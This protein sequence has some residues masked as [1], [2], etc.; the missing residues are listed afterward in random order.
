MPIPSL[1]E[2]SS[3]AIDVTRATTRASSLWL[4]VSTLDM[5]LSTLLT[6]SCSPSNSSHKYIISNASFITHN[7]VIPE[8][9]SAAKGDTATSTSSEKQAENTPKRSNTIY[10]TQLMCKGRG[11]P[12][13]VPQP[14]LRLPVAQRAQGVSI[15]DVGIITEYGAF[16]FL[17]N[18]CAAADD[19][20]NPPDL[21]EGFTTLHLSAWDV[22]EFRDFPNGS[23]LASPSIG[24]AAKGED[25]RTTTFESAEKEGALLAMPQ[26]AYHEEVN[27]LSKFRDHAEQHVESWYRF[28]MHK[29][30]RRD[31]A[32]G[33]IRLVV[34]VDKSTTWGMA[35]FADPFQLQL[36]ETDG[37]KEVDDLP[38]T[39][40]HTGTSGEVKAGPDKWENEDI[41]PKNGARVRNQTLFARTLNIL[42]G[43][44]AWAKVDTQRNKR[45]PSLILTVANP[46]YEEPQTPISIKASTATMGEKPSNY[47]NVTVENVPRPTE[48]VKGLLSMR[49]S[50][51]RSIQR[52][53]RPLSKTPTLL[54]LS[55]PSLILSAGGSN[56]AKLP[57]ETKPA[58]LQ[59]LRRSHY[60]D[61]GV[62]QRSTQPIPS[63]MPEAVEKRMDLSDT[64]SLS[65]AISQFDSIPRPLDRVR[66][67]PRGG[68]A[69]TAPIRL[70][71]LLKRN[72]PI[73][74]DVDKPKHPSLFI[75]SWLLGANNPPQT[76]CIKMAI[77]HDSV[78]YGLLLEGSTAE[79]LA[80]SFR[81]RHAKDLEKEIDIVQK[82]YDICLTSSQQSM[83]LEP[84]GY[85]DSKSSAAR[86]EM[87]KTIEAL[88]RDDNTIKNYLFGFQV[89]EVVPTIGGGADSDMQ[90]QPRRLLLS[91]IISRFASENGL[92]TTT[93]NTPFPLDAFK[94]LQHHP[95]QP[96][97][98]DS[99][100]QVLHGE[101][102]L[103][104]A[105]ERQSIPAIRA[106]LRSVNEGD[107]QAPA[108]LR[109][110]ANRLLNHGFDFADK[111]NI[112][113]AIFFYRHAEKVTPINS[114]QYLEIVLGLCNA[115]HCR[116]RLLGMGE[117]FDSLMRYLDIQRSLDFDAILGELK[118]KI[119]RGT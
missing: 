20:I 73:P 84:M 30:G 62:P 108:I 97:T 65:S 61:G 5:M 28:V 89:G 47:A 64:S 40:E 69:F 32:N 68:P 82:H 95:C 91:Q 43:S 81:L 74:Q 103:D 72:V 17:F 83:Y 58:T 115:H 106:E 55:K 51:P 39:W 22:R 70:P 110:L 87:E 8:G 60:I 14:N 117:D 112:D 38:Y 107:A 54:G 44:E 37:M 2:H 75:N 88:R 93:R 12:L 41:C 99:L 67:N 53:P 18:I 85:I 56:P 42:L 94:P 76:P 16:D 50:G 101:V 10:E 102:L 118:S 26:G 19:P 71:A 77:T 27:D 119:R 116:Y 52:S 9:A 80:L 57:E 4:R 21:P 98:L 100:L 34:G 114:Y 13:W 96:L 66:L 15:G 109:R 113:E 25:R 105:L 111:D 49:P 33:D 1:D 48:K 63:N 11:F 92:S 90:P 86:H 46:E 29:R 45:R 78:W 35:S 79:A 7:Y 104:E 59:T 3:R 24:K 31:T 6:T 23:Y 36:R